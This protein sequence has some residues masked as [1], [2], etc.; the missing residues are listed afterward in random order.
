MIILRLRSRKSHQKPTL[1]DILP[2]LNYI[3][4]K[5]T[6]L[7]LF[8]FQAHSPPR[9]P[10]FRR[11]IPAT[12]YMESTIQGTEALIAFESD[13]EDVLSGGVPTDDQYFLLYFIMGTYFAPHLK[14]ETPQKSVLQRR[15]EG[16]VLY[17]SDQLAGSHIKVVEV[18][19]IYY[20]VLRK[21][22]ASVVMKLAWLHQFLD[23]T[24]PYPRETATDYPQFKDLFPPDLHPQSWLKD[25]YKII[26]NVVFIDK[27]ETSC[28]KA[29]DITRFK[30]LTRL[31]DF[32]LDR[33]SARSH[34][35]VDGKIQCNM[36][37]E[38]DCNG[39]LPQTRLSGAPRKTK[40]PNELAMPKDT[41]QRDVKF[42]DIVDRRRSPPVSRA[43]DMPTVSS[44]EHNGKPSL[45]GEVDPFAVEGDSSSEE[46]F[47]PGMIFFPSHPT[48]EE[49]SNMTAATK[50]T[51]ITGSAAKGQIGPALGLIDIGECED[52]YLFRVSL[53]GVRRDER[54]FSCEV[55]DDGKVLIRGVTVTG[56]KTVCRYSQTFEMQSQN[57]CP[58][59]HFSIFFK[60][61]GPVDPQ[62]FSGNFGTDGILEGIVMKEGQ[63][64]W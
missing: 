13:K 53:P 40:N 61:P 6:T 1:L 37:L 46:N 54:E 52:S 4:S 5:Y 64:S 17:T 47:G 29:E 15:F 56:E 41:M 7:T 62:Q 28:L 2:L 58:P 51:A 33:D 22:D 57:L 45:F 44:S 8:L 32:H 25:K 39:E 11:L 59:G 49:L 38:V 36:M 21:A 43:A 14:Q 34:A 20:Y 16:L 48:R 60:L 18:E 3:D 55:E 42:G 10:N 27:P 23:G 35:F 24:L 26:G 12:E 9:A 63:N 31:E 19:R 50:G 30:R